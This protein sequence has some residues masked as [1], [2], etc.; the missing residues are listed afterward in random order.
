MSFQ[1]QPGAEGSLSESVHFPPTSGFH[2]HQGYHIDGRMAMAPPSRAPRGAPFVHED[3][4][5]GGAHYMHNGGFDRAEYDYGLRRHSCGEHLGLHS[6]TLIEHLLLQENQK[7]LRM[8]SLVQSQ[9]SGCLSGCLSCGLSEKRVRLQDSEELMMEEQR[10]YSRSVGEGPSRSVNLG[11][12]ADGGEYPE[13][14]FRHPRPRQSIGGV[15]ERS[16]S[17]ISF[18]EEELGR[19]LY[20]GRRISYPAAHPT[21]SHSQ[22]SHHVQDQPLHPVGAME[23]SVP[24]YGFSDADG[25]VRQRRPIQRQSL[26]ENGTEDDGWHRASRSRAGPASAREQDRLSFPGLATGSLPRNLVGSPHRPT[27]GSERPAQST[28]TTS[29]SLPVLPENS[30]EPSYQDNVLQQASTQRVVTQ[31]P[32]SLTNWYIIKV[33][34]V[35]VGRVLETKVAVGGLLVQNGEHVKTSPI[36]NRLDIH[37]VVTEDGVE[38]SL[39]GTIDQ[40]TST[41]NGFAPGIIQC[42]SAGFPYMWKQ[43]LRVRPVGESSGLAVSESLGGLHPKASKCHSEDE[44]QGN[45]DPKSFKAILQG[46][47][48]SSRDY[49]GDS[50]APIVNAEPSVIETP[51]NTTFDVVEAAVTARAGTSG[52]AEAIV[53]ARAGTSGAAEATVSVRAETSETEVVATPSTLDAVAPQGDVCKTGCLGTATARAEPSD[54]IETDTAVLLSAEVSDAIKTRCSSQDVLLQPTQDASLTSLNPVHE[55]EAPAPATETPAAKAPAPALV[56]EAQVP[57]NETPGPV[58]EAP[59]EFLTTDS[60]SKEAENDPAIDTT[61]VT[62]RRGRKNK[63]GSSQL[64]LRSSKRLQQRQSS[65]SEFTLTTMD[66]SGPAQTEQVAP[67]MNIVAD[68]SI[69]EESAQIMPVVKHVQTGCDELT[70]TNSIIEEVLEDLQQAAIEVLDQCGFLGAD[71]VDIATDPQP[72]E[73]EEFDQVQDRCENLPKGTDGVKDPRLKE[74]EITQDEIEG[75]EVEETVP[76]ALP[77]VAS[78]EVEE[79]VPVAPPSVANE[80]VE[81]TVPV[82]PP[83]VAS[84][85]VEETVSVAP[86]SVANEE[87]EETVP[88]APPSVASEEVEKTVSVAPPSVA[89]EEVEETVPIPPE[90]ENEELEESAPVTPPELLQSKFQSRIGSLSKPS[91]EGVPQGSGE[92][93]FPEF[94][95]RMTRSLKRRL[96][97]TPTTETAADVAPI[98]RSSKRLR[99]HSGAATPSVRPNTNLDT[100]RRE[101]GPNVEP[102]P[103]PVTTHQNEGRSV[104]PDSNPDTPHQEDADAFF[105]RVRGKSKSCTVKAVSCSNWKRLCSP[106]DILRYNSNVVSSEV[107]PEQAVE[108]VLKVERMDYPPLASQNA[109]ETSRMAEHLNRDQIETSATRRRCGRLKRMK[110]ANRFVKTVTSRKLLGDDTG[111]GSSGRRLLGED[112]TNGS[113]EKTLLGVDS[114][115]GSAG[116][117]KLVAR[118]SGK[119]SMK[120]LE[121]SSIRGKCRRTSII[122]PPLP[123]PRVQDKSKVPEAFGLKT[124]RSGRLLVPPLAYWRSQSIEY[125]KDGGIIAIFDGFQAKPADTGCFN[126]TPPQEKEAK[127]IQERL[128]KAAATVK[129]R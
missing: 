6:G 77:S 111:K 88:V 78:E 101:E 34:I 119:G 42:L 41:A 86:P 122:P 97:L 71:S 80:E 100:I 50:P 25:R 129:K 54:E 108:R 59:V 3:G 121:A 52:A 72:M 4:R 2:E 27:G 5:G 16:Q 85:E 26:S 15:G 62:I 102:S 58:A 81:E 14:W 22:A 83:S 107:T 118:G 33:Q 47:P 103:N 11:A 40:E 114:A 74:K 73:V 106:E 84:E 31:G 115:E 64:P 39:E 87:V 75:V 55:T 45:I 90:F 13:G 94:S 19:S 128:C 113:I 82:A 49:E 44:S 116:D 63:K 93:I 24:I 36:V 8:A 12:E 69:E 17:R 21:I 23:S 9:A 76:V 37:K 7:A 79:T 1:L 99:R 28:R 51:S 30:A 38:V 104:E 43:L 29:Q 35:E 46:M 67:G 105:V 95:A 117:R 112:S 53:S 126:F 96:K 18:S 110:P 123:P 120:G 127:R 89:S 57:P 98:T 10:C 91:S 65:S 48:C 61:L 32:V 124:S 20:Q 68:K 92:R 66:S 125:D 109:A 70:M 56:T 60:L